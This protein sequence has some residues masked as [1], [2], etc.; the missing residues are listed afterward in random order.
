[1][2][3]EKSAGVV[4]FRRKGSVKEYLIL[5]YGTKHWDFP[6]GHLEGNESSIEAAIRETKEETGLNVKIIEGFKETI[7]YMFRTNYSQGEIIY[8]NVD[9]F[10]GEVDLNEKVKLSHEHSEYRW[11]TYEDAMNSLTFQNAKNI[12]SKVHSFTKNL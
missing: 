9:F 8:K 3:F 1:M 6:K 4:V 7:S 12:L 10:T 2:L 11:E 5:K